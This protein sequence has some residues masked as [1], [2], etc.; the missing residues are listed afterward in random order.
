[1]FH[2]RGGEFAFSVTAPET[3]FE[4]G[5]AGAYADVCGSVIEGLA[6][7]GIEAELVDTNSIVTGGRKISGNSQRRSRG[8]LQQHGTV[9]YEVDEELMFS[10]LGGRAD[11]G[12]C[13]PSKPRPVACV[14]ESAEVTFDD[15]YAAIRDALLDGRDLEVGQLT[16]EELEMGEELVREKYTTASWTYLL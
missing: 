16:L 12:R 8:V 14:A 7:L 9:L 10:V 11:R 1:M 3:F 6:T 2:Q 15:T 4:G 5:L 13:T